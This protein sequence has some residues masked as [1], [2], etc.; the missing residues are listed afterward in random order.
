M[1][2]SNIERFDVLTGRVLAE[3]YQHFPV[4]LDLAWS[5]RDLFTGYLTTFTDVLKKMSRLKMI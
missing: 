4:D 2:A 5:Y 1:T 3:L